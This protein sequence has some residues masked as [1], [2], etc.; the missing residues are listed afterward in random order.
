MRSLNN[1]L[2]LKLIFRFNGDHFEFSTSAYVNNISLSAIE[3]AILENMVRA[4][5]NLILSCL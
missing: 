3:W 2:N 5:G 4:L 1:V